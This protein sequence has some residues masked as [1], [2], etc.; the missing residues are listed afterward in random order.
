MAQQALVTML[1]KRWRWKQ[2]KIKR[3]QGIFW[4]KR[5]TATRAT[6]PSLAFTKTKAYSTS[7]KRKYQPKLASQNPVNPLCQ[8]SKIKAPRLKWLETAAALLLT[9]SNKITRTMCNI[10]S[11]AASIEAQESKCLKKS[12]SSGR[13]RV[14]LSGPSVA[15]RAIRNCQCQYPSRESGNWHRTKICKSLIGA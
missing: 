14:T 5:G 4:P 1:K 3:C 13:N 7:L 6:S 11:L 10:F 15:Q 12:T 9:L 8:S 2:M